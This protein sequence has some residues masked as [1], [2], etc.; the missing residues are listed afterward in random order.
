MVM[1]LVEEKT[2]MLYY[3]NL[4]HPWS[5][6]Y[7]DKTARFIENDFSCRKLGFLGDTRQLQVKLLTLK[8][9]DYLIC[10]SD[11]RDDIYHTDEYGNRQMNSD[12]NKFLRI[13]EKAD[14]DLNDIYNLLNESGKISD[15]LSLMVLHIEKTERSSELP[16][17]KDIKLIHEAKIKLDSE[18]YD[19]CSL[20]LD[21]VGSKNSLSFINLR[22]KLLAR[23][24]RPQE[25]LDALLK[26]FHEHQ[27]ENSKLMLRLAEN[28]WQ[29]KKYETAL[30]YAEALYLRDAT[31]IRTAQRLAYMHEKTGNTARSLEILERI[32]GLK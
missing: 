5:V 30:D 3:V 19:E 28:F 32:A 10:G 20:L 9:S 15:D 1:G 16:D 22:L 12:E 4:E 29:L 17:E 7:R 6:L 8:D 27:P 21:S 18:N 31:N 25:Y 2:G 11:G 26:A 13:I 14:A 24:S 23:N